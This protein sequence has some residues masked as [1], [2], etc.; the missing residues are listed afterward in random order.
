LIGT[1]YKAVQQRSENLSVG[2]RLIPGRRFVEKTRQQ[3][4]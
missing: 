1:L 3:N 2:K 4:T